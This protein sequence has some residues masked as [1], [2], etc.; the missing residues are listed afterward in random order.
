MLAALSV[1]VLPLAACTDWHDGH[2]TVQPLDCEKVRCLDTTLTPGHCN[3]SGNGSRLIMFIVMNSSSQPVRYKLEFNKAEVM[4]TNDA[5]PDHTALDQNN[6][7]ERHDFWSSTY[8]KDVTISTVQLSQDGKTVVDK[9][10]V[11]KR[12]K[13]C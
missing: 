3:A 8:D 13:R 10:D 12:L 5:A 7:V 6:N 4:P 1:C 9:Q 2:I 11:T